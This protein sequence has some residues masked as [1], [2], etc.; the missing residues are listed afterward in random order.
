MTRDGFFA[1]WR[2]VEYP[3]SPSSAGAHLYTDR[4]DG[5]GFEPVAAGRYR[6]VV[7]FGDLDEFGYVSTVGTFRGQPVK[8]LAEHDGWLR[9]E[10]T[11]GDASVAERLGLERFDRGVYQSWVPSVEVSPLT[12]H[13]H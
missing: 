4:P 11:G 13:R 8:V 9:V 6:R 5:H 1:R 2:G 3:A 12:E 10:Y 7:P